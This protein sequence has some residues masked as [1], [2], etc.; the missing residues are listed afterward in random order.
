MASSNESQSHSQIQFE[1]GLI[2]GFINSSFHWKRAFLSS[3]NSHCTVK[4]KDIFTIWEIHEKWLKSVSLF[5]IVSWI[6][7]NLLYLKLL[8][9]QEVFY[10]V[11]L[12]N[13]HTVRNIPIFIHKATY[14]ILV[15]KT[16][17]LKHLLSI[18]LKGIALMFLLQKEQRVCLF[19][20]RNKWTDV[21]RLWFLF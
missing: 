3:D 21:K 9:Y 20:I 17:Q 14:F 1:T 16:R 12:A 4:Y 7:F 15:I 8:L 19:P 18:H 5:G 13:N 2:W 10:L 6:I 11:Q